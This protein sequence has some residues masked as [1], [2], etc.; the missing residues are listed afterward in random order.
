MDAGVLD[1]FLNDLLIKEDLHKRIQSLDGQD[2][3]RVA[4]GSSR[5]YAASLL[6]RQVAGRAI[7]RQKMP[8]WHADIRIAYPLKQNIG[9]ASQHQAAALKASLCKGYSVAD[10]TGGTGIDAWYMAQ[11]AREFLYNETNPELFRL[12]RHNL[13]L[14]NLQSIF[15]SNHTA[16]GVW[17]DE[18]LL[19]P[20]EVIFLD[21]SRLEEGRKVFALKD[22][23]PDITQIPAYILQTKKLMVKLG[24][25]LDI[26]EVL[27]VLPWVRQ[28]VVVSIRNEV[29]ELLALSWQAFNGEVIQAIELDWRG[30]CFRFQAGMAGAKQAGELSTEY[31]FEP[32][33]A[34]VKAGL[35]RAYGQY[36]GLARIH[37]EVSLYFCPTP[38]ILFGKTYRIL[39]RL[40]GKPEDIKKRYAKNPV[41]IASRGFAMSAEE[42]ASRYK[43]KTGGGPMLYFT[44]VMEAG[45]ERHLCLV[46]ERIFA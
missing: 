20:Y 43:F 17:K 35:T 40:P 5:P 44:R 42:I 28:I 21:P 45:T 34:L 36:P 19:Q 26:Q 41:D 4:M 18:L 27:K 38:D 14:L 12:A 7:A 32:G 15:F 39:E 29:K 3:A 16:E 37:P 22:Y 24:P 23:S 13:G 46:V 9:Q 11:D 1:S 8:A 25:M 33:A 6:A 2:P 30:H 10:L 31:L